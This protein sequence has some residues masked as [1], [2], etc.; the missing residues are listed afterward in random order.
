MYMFA[1]PD[2]R[3]QTE[4]VCNGRRS[5][6]ASTQWLQKNMK[7]LFLFFI[8]IF[9]YLFI[10]LFNFLRCVYLL[11]HQCVLLEQQKEFPYQFIYPYFSIYVFIYIYIYDIYIYIYI[12]N[13]IYIYMYVYIFLENP[14]IL[15]TKC[16]VGILDITLTFT[17]PIYIS[18]AI[19]WECFI[20]LENCSM[21]F[22]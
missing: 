5:V 3:K 21:F 10:Y 8:F 18:W 1:M 22:C 14:S 17:T 7:K 9:I 11:D 16:C 12:Y 20:I 4:E 19:L 2:A 13:M 6:C 15:S